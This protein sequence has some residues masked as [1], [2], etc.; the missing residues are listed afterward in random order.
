MADLKA[1]K[2]KTVRWETS[3]AYHS[4]LMKSLEID[5]AQYKAD[6]T[7]SLPQIPLI[8]GTTG[9]LSPDAMTKI[10]YW[11]SLIRE[12][13]RFATGMQTM[14]EQGV[15]VFIEIGAK[16]NLLSMGIRCLPEGV[17]VWLPSLRPG[18]SSWQQLLSSLAQLYILGVPVNWSGFDRDYRRDRLRLPTYPF[19]RQSYWFS[20]SRSSQPSNL[21]PL[22]HCSLIS[23]LL[24]RGDSAQEI[25]QLLAQTESFSSEEVQLLPKLITAL[26]G[27]HQETAFSTDEHKSS[28]SNLTTNID[29]PIPEVIA[30]ESAISLRRSQ[31]ATSPEEQQQQL[32]EYLTQQ[33]AKVLGLA[34]SQLDVEQPLN[35][36]GLD[37]L[38]LVQLVNRIK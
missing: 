37:S 20:S 3:Y 23:S 17:G 16:P 19:E 31:L 1:Q 5:F 18:Q 32:E 24:D 21:S 8:S 29:V 34:P 2:V 35:T 13:M 6:Y 27:H 28:L 11:V 36:L 30:P 38:M 15:T 26:V 33:I 22:H 25:V 7:P 12:P 4:P 14:H 9:Q 10:D